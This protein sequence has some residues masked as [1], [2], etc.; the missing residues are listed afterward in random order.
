VAGRRLYNAR[1]WQIGIITLAIV[2]VAGASGIG[3]YYLGTHKSSVNSATTVAGVD[4]GTFWKAWGIVNDK[5]FGDTTDT[6]K[7][8]DGSISGMVASLNDPYTVYLAPKQN[9]LFQSGLQ[10][11]FGGI[12]AELEVKNNLLTIVSVLEGTPSEKSGLK[13]EDIITQIDGKKTADMAFLDA[14]DMIRGDAGTKVTLTIVRA[15]VDKAFPVEVTRDTIVVKSVSTDTLGTNKDIA[16]IKVNQFGEDTVTAFQAALVATKGKKGLVLDLRNN[17]GGFLN[18]AVQM[19]GMVIPATPAGDSTVLQ[20]RTAV[21]ERDKDKSEHP[22]KATNA[23]IADTIPMVVLVNGGS[24][25]A[26]EIFSGA[27]KDYQRAT[28]LGTQTFGKGSVQDL[29]DLGNG[30]SIKVTIAKWFTPLG[31]GID[32]KGITPDTIITLPDSVTP[33]KTDAQ[34][35]KALEI[36]TSK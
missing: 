33:S 25:S 19:I 32:G 6:T 7:R 31:T 36:L 30:G 18:A 10:G 1:V 29:V 2:V 13:P 15:G 11:N 17:P 4:L 8:V 12:G 5:F 21:L 16:Y 35:Q 34:V 23:P 14:I 9:K 27:M 26:S 28:V 24:A 22:Y 3:G 20:Q